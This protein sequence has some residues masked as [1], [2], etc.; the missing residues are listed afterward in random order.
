MRLIN[1]ISE[2]ALQAEQVSGVKWGDGG[3]VLDNLHFNMLENLQ[4]LHAG[5]HLKTNLIR[6]KAR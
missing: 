2:Q 1:F 4:I 3:W 6:R 5:E